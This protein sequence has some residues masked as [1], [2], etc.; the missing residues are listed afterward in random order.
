MFSALPQSIT[1]KEDTML[2][3]GSS[4][5]TEYVDETDTM[6]TCH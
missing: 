2:E 3:W 4:E 6:D 1:Q 5:A